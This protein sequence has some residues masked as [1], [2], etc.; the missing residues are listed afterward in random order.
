MTI[1]DNS[2]TYYPQ[3]VYT[4]K[5]MESSDTAQPRETLAAGEINITANVTVSF[6]LE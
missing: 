6:I 4:M 2:Q 3:P 1:S 5:V